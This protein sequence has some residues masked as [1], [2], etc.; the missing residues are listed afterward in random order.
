MTPSDYYLFWNLKFDHGGFCYPQW[1][2]TRASFVD[3]KNYIN[4]ND[5]I[6]AP[7]SHESVKDV[8]FTD[9]YVYY[10]KYDCLICQGQK[11]LK[12]PS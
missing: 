2:T 12:W 1:W 6:S 4:Y 10:G 5:A 3:A 8:R 9:V 7:D 11:L